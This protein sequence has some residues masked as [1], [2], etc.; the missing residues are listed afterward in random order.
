MLLLSFTAAAAFFHSFIGFNSLLFSSFFFCFYQ[1]Y[2]LNDDDIFMFGYLRRRS[3]STNEEERKVEREEERV[4]VRN[5]QEHDGRPNM[6][7][8]FFRSF[9]LLFSVAAFGQEPHL[10]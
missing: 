4:L 7:V 3:T 5:D 9:S 6:F 2:A 8:S 1:L 10:Y